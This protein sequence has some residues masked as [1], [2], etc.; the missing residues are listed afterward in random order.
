MSSA[1]LPPPASLTTAALLARVGD[2]PVNRICFD[3]K[4]GAAT[5][6]D[7]LDLHARTGRLYELIDGILVEK[8]MGHPEG[9]LAA[10][11]IYFLNVWVMPRNLGAW[12]PLTR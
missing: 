9:F 5:E 4:P 11:L 12:A 3:L 8:P 2:I 7:L 1:T 6:Q 10:T